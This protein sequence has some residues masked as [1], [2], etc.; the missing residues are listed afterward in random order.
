[1]EI[2]HPEPEITAEMNF[3]NR[4]ALRGPKS[5]YSMK[6]TS[7]CAQRA[8]APRTF[9]GRQARCPTEPQPRLPC[10]FISS[11]FTPAVLAPALT[12][13]MA[14]AVLSTYPMTSS[15]EPTVFGMDAFP[16]KIK[17]R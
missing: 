2:A 10:H 6:I 12:Y 15:S 5:F 14:P 1:V 7:A 3:W 8:N 17:L 13:P 11:V 16:V 4:A 9:A